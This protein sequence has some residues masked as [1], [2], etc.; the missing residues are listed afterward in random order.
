MS[1]ISEIYKARLVSAD[2]AVR[3]IPDDARIAVGLGVAQPP[4]LLAALGRR[5]AADELMRVRLYYMLS[6][7]I[8]G[9]TFLNERFRQRL[10][11]MSIFHS[12]VERVLDQRLKSVGL[13]IR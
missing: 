7:S 3:L 5:A 6:T 9:D 10:T 13:P 8:G 11:P 2:E 12:A 4:E 1:S